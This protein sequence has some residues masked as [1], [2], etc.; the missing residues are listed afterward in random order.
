MEGMQGWSQPM[1]CWLGH[2]AGPTVAVVHNVWSTHRV[3]PSQ[4]GAGLC[5]QPGP[6]L[7]WVTT[8]GG[9]AETDPAGA[10]QAYIPGQAHSSESSLYM[11]GRVMVPSKALVATKAY[12]S[13]GYGGHAEVAPADP[14]LACGT[15]HYV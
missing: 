14:V 11:E 6:R 12:G 7:R 2:S 15:C 5:T 10:L 8:A 4:C 1:L 9:H 13:N 3:G